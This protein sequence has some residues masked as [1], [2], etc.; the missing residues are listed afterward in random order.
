LDGS[1]LYWGVA[2]ENQLSSE[3]S[4]AEAF[5]AF[6]A[7]SEPKL[8]HSLCSALG[9]Q[10]GHEATADALAYGWEHWDQVSSMDNPVGYLYK[11]GRDMGRRHFRRRAPILLSLPSPARLP[12]VEPDLAAALG[13]LPERQRVAVMLVHSFGWTLS[14]TADHLGVAKGTVQ[15][16]LNRG[17]SALRDRLG[18]PHD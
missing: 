15:T 17:M 8:R 6:V 11:V 16:H 13:A 7:T 12:D 14:E 2:I 1:T 9:S 18:V 10:I 3:V 5:T 4:V